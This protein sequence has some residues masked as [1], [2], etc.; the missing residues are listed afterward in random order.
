[1][2]DEAQPASSRPLQE[3]CVYCGT[4]IPPRGVYC[5]T[6]GAVRESMRDANP[7]PVGL[8]RLPYGYPAYYPWQRP[9][10]PLRKLIK[11]VSAYI[12]LSFLIDLVVSMVALVYGSTIVSPEIMDSSFGFE[13]FLVLPVIVPL[14]TLSDSVLLVYYFLII[15]AILAS[16]AV[17]F[18]KGSKPFLKE[19]KMEGKS[20]DHSII[21]ETT[22][23]L[24][25]TLF[26]SLIIA[27]M[28]NPSEEDLPSVGTTAEFL[29]VLA[30]A[31][32]WEEI[33]V[34]VLMIG[35]PLVLVDL[36]RRRGLRKPQKYVLGGGFALGAPE[37]ILLMVSSIIFGFAHYT[38]GWGAWKIFP[39]T[40]GGLA[41]G[42]LFLRFGI[43]AS[44]TLH[45]GTD[46]LSA[47]AEVTGSL[48]VGVVI[49]IAAV[50]WA[51]FGL[52]F[53]AYYSIRIVEFFTGRKLLE[54]KET[55]VREQYPGM[56]TW[57]P[58]PDLPFGLPRQDAPIVTA[59]ETMRP[60]EGYSQAV[61]GPPYA[62]VCPRCGSVEARWRDGRFECLRCGHLG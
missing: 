57:M 18:L 34:R 53:F 25:A 30:N 29:F 50:V 2:S 42:Y 7:P 51:A 62:Y 58:P 37:V 10:T 35:L 46:Y 52:M 23:L 44:I 17:F 20:R 4:V 19:L 26:F 48:A 39:A 43:V 8:R 27:L 9:R 32:V 1:M 55:P 56:V 14:V 61:G 59:H 36:A 6:C 22:G 28:A 54:E 31:S 40:V 5:P 60:A 47:P 38:G 13:L 15:A 41:F 3:F 45:F 21:F 12:M 16:C 11:T 24:F 49:G 33:V